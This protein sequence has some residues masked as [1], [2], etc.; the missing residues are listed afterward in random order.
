MEDQDII[1]L[2][3]ARN[4]D[5]IKESS[6]KYGGY[7]AGISMSILKNA[8]DAEECVNDTWL[9]AWN[10]IPPQNPPSVFVFLHRPP[11]P[12]AY[13]AGNRTPYQKI[14]FFQKNFSKTP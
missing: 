5:A 11:S 9:K 13:D 1:A 10:S 4:E 3:F 6:V 7:A 12:R 2:Y 8:P 14:S